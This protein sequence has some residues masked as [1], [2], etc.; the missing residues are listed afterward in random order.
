[1]TEE[2]KHMDEWKRIQA[3]FRAKSEAPRDVWDYKSRCVEG[4]ITGETLDYN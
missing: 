1:M 2:D 3:E 4:L